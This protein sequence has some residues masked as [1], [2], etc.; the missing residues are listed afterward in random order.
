MTDISKKVHGILHRL[1]LHKNSLSTELRI[2]LVLAFVFPIIDY[3]CVVY[4][5]LSGELNV[6]LQRLV[7][8]TIRFIYNLERDEH[9]TPFRHRLS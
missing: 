5:D 9:I 6:K 7:N 1:K 8:S 4:N 2:N 3:C